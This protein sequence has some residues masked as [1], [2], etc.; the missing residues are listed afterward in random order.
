MAR[1]EVCRRQSRQRDA[2]SPRSAKESKEIQRAA[3]SSDGRR[4]HERGQGKSP[5]QV[6]MQ[7]ENGWKPEGGE[8]STAGPELAASLRGRKARAGKAYP[9]GEMPS[10]AELGKINKGAL[11]Q[12]LPEG[13]ALGCS[14][15][16]ISG[17]VV[18]FTF[19]FDRSS[20]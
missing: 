2:L 5:N 18:F 8:K 1:V 15:R 14:Q 10:D 9:V 17:W 13:T 4:W 11:G 19:T 20:W 3:K 16:C 7:G 12:N 6:L